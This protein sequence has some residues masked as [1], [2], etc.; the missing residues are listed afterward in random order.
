MKKK[1]IG[2]VGGIILLGEALLLA[3]CGVN[4][5]EGIKEDVNTTTTQESI[6]IST[7][8]TSVPEVDLNVNDGE[9]SILTEDGAYL[10][11]D[12]VYTIYQGGT[13]NLV[14]VLNGKIEVCVTSANAS[15]IYDVI[16]ELNGVTITY[17]KD[18]PIYILESTDTEISYDVEISAQNGTQNIINDL[19]EKKSEEENLGEAAIYSE[20]DLKLKGKGELYVYGN[21]NNGI[22]T[23][24]DL[25]IKNLTL[26]VNAL[27]NAIK[28]NDSV[29]IESG[30][31]TFIS[32]GGDGIKTSN[33][34]LSSK[35]NQKGMVTL[36]GGDIQIFACCDGI[37]S[38]FDVVI[39]DSVNLSIYTDTYSS[40][41]EEVFDLSESTTLTSLNFP[42]GHGGGPGGGQGG[43][44]GFDE[45]NTDKSS[46]SAKGIKVSNEINI[47]GGNIYI[48]AYDDGIHANN[49]TLIEST[50]AY[51]N[52][53]VNISGGEVII[54][55]SDDGIHADTTINITDNAYINVKKSYEGIEANQIVFDGGTTYVYSTND[56]VNAALCGS[57]LTPA[58]YIKN[59]YVD[60]DCASGDT[61]TIDSNGNVYIS[62]GVTVIKNR[63]QGT[64]SMTGGTLD[65]D[66]T[67]SITGGVL[68]SFGTWCSE[69]NVTATKSSSSTLSSGTYTLKDS[70]GN[71]IIT[72]TLSVSY[73]GYRLFNKT[74]DSYTLYKDSSTVVSF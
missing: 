50:N 49:D 58:L 17:D 5:K 39:S 33:S 62:G 44:G 37:D 29:T 52:G 60:L 3:S 27:N 43:P 9:F 48:K 61:D 35:G 20:V 42:G 38:A 34:S 28:G 69:A 21:Y 57:T 64:S 16:L 2:I 55:A 73:Y 8:S 59:G 67:V 65:V 10:K 13:Y 71:E 4:S 63:Q 7:P 47:S 11:N 22:H 24:D 41:T 15:G 36:T 66:Y 1:C 74:N 53:I 31:H 56:A 25:K 14:G 12:N 6:S 68:M 19:R 70:S 18:S 26:V 32:T 30:S 46:H 45:G 23:K 40:Y 54:E 51:G 72:T